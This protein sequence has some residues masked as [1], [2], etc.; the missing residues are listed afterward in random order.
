MHPQLRHCRDRLATSMRLHQHMYVC[1]PGPA[2]HLFPF[3]WGA[4]DAPTDG[5]SHQTLQFVTPMTCGQQ[6]EHYS[7]P[8]MHAREWG[9]TPSMRDLSART[10]PGTAMMQRDS[11]SRKEGIRRSCPAATGWVGCN[12]QHAHV[13]P[14]WRGLHARLA[15]AATN[16]MQNVSKRTI[17]T[18]TCMN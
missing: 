10:A 3:H 12:N 1:A 7:C 4:P 2:S 5:T 15:W 16:N 13:L 18:V 6:P 17:T 8:A 11:G 9:A 14:G